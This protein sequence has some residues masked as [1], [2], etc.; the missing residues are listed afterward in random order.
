MSLTIG[1]FARRGGVS[2]R[3]LRQYDRLGLLHPTRV[4]ESSG[5]SYYE[6]AA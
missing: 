5:Y 4:D 1:D 2:A 6:A 3:L